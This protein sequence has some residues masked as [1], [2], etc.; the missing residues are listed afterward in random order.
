MFKM[1]FQ[2]VN[3]PVYTPPLPNIQ[4]ASTSL[5]NLGSIFTPLKPTGPCGSCG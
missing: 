4:I 2:V 1:K 5:A 3:K